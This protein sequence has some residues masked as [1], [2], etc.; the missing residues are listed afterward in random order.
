[1]TS[2]AKNPGLLGVLLGGAVASF[3]LINSGCVPLAT[4][5][6]ADHQA[7]INA[8]AMRDAALINARANGYQNSNVQNNYTRSVPFICSY[9][10]DFN[11]DQC[12]DPRPYPIGE[13]VD[14]GKTVF[15]VGDKIT[16]AVEQEGHRG[17]TLKTYASNMSDFQIEEISSQNIT[18]DRSTP[19][20]TSIITDKKGI[21]QIYWTIDGAKIGEHIIQVK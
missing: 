6:A 11:K 14:R 2:R 12:V 18:L 3:S 7:V 21:F 20:T 16:Y 5:I 9:T 10:E 8:R 1:M 13:A 19:Q 4:L 17:K 15:N